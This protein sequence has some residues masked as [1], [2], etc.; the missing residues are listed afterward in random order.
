M[1]VP[2][3]ISDLVGCDLVSIVPAADIAAGAQRPFARLGSQ[4]WSS[5]GRLFVYSQASA[6][7]PAFSSTCT[8]NLVS[9]LATSG[10]GTYL[11]PSTSMVAGDQG[12]FSKPSV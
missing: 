4:V 9:F 3:T 2:F 12:W 6:A 11:S 7:I 5:D 1:A 8:V 10:G